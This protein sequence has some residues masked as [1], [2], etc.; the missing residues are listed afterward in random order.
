MTTDSEHK[1]TTLAYYDGNAK[2]FYEGTVN[3]NMTVIYTPFLTYMPSYAAILDAGCGSGRDTLFFSG[4]GY[5]V[6]AFDNSPTLVKMASKLTGQE[7]LNLSFQELDFENRFNGIWACS[8]LVH[9][10]SDELR[11][12]FHRLS[13]SLKVDGVMYASFK[14]GTGEHIRN[15]RLFVDLD[16]AG[17]NRLIDW[18]PEF[19]MVRCWKSSDLRP[20]RQN[21]KWLNALVRKNGPT[22]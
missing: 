6:T 12:V 10:P 4:K 18:H 17:F 14:Y 22:G 13:R 1:D 2:Q 15:G 16:E 8:S 19:S 3:L 20:G 7:I 21:E 5:R 11:D 9:V